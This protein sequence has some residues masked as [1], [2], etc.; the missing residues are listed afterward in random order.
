MGG[1]VQRSHLCICASGGRGEGSRGAAGN[2]VRAGG[3][4]QPARGS[5]SKIGWGWRQQ[6]AKENWIRQKGVGGHATARQPQGPALQ[7]AG[8]LA[9]LVWVCMGCRFPGVWQAA[10]AAA[11]ATPSAHR[12]RAGGT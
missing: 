8:T 9:E 11:A 4:C 3:R 6:G 5:E 12:K 1:A 7:A 2:S 10:G